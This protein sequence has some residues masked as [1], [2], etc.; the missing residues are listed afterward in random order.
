M[1]ALR[2]KRNRTVKNKIL[3]FVESKTEETYLNSW[4]QLNKSSSVKIVK[5]KGTGRYII[6]TVLSKLSNDKSLRDYK[7]SRQIVVFDKDELVSKSSFTL[8]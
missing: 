4:R 1:S 2:V 6:K 7:N 5:I 8:R 3:I